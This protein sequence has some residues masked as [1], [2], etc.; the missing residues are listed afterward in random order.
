MHIPDKSP[1][2]RLGDGIVVGSPFFTF[3]EE[4]TKSAQRERLEVGVGEPVT[5]GVPLWIERATWTMLRRPPRSQVELRDAR[6]CADVPGVYIVSVCIDGL[7]RREL[8][9][10]AFP[11]EFGGRLPVT[12]ERRLQVRSWTVEPGR[13]LDEIIKRLEPEK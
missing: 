6:L 4:H 1:G 10:C 13:T 3:E 11:K 8:A 7:W 9:L 5:L 12:E 2:G